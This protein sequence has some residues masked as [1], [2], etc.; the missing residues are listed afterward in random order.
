MKSNIQNHESEKQ[1][2]KIIII[3]TLFPPSSRQIGSFS[4]NS[5]DELFSST[6]FTERLTAMIEGMVS[7]FKVNL[8][9]QETFKE[10][11][12][13]EPI[14]F[15]DLKPDNVPQEELEFLRRNEDI[16]DLSAQISFQDCWED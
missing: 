13:F 11:D 15:A 4:D 7:E 2:V 16:K 10:D 14:Y 9:S 5:I 12:P 8:I 3:P 1:S 6:H